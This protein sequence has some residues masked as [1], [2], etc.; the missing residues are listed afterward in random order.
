MNII[1]RIIVARK[2]YR[3]AGRI[4]RRTRHLYIRLVWPAIKADAT[5][6]LIE[7][8][9]KRMIDSGMYALPKSER[10]VRFSILRRAWKIETGAPGR[11][12]HPDGWFLWL[13]RNGF[14]R[15]WR[16]EIRAIA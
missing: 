13:N 1:E 8:C 6:R 2:A 7:A 9:A 16:R 5:G 10:D 3:D 4:I 15:E 14:S 12:G 11:F